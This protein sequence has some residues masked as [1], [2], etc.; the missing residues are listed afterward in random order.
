MERINKR[1]CLLLVLA[2]AFGTVACFENRTIVLSGGSTAPFPLYSQFFF[3]WQVLRPE[4][5]MQYAQTTSI[6]GMNTIVG[7]NRTSVW[8]GTDLEPTLVQKENA[9][10][11]GRDLHMFPSALLSVVPFA[12]YSSLKVSGL[13]LTGR[14]LAL[15]WLGNIS[16]WNDPAIVAT[17]PGLASV[18]QSIMLVVQNGASGTLSIFQ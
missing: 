14:T 15:I 16:R 7:P 5:D 2:L 4:V 3:G 11:N 17:N 13:K 9:L 10:A 1:L 18:N 12:H 8:V 6:I